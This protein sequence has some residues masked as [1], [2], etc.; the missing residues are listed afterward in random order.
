M[1]VCVSVSPSLGE[2]V[3][4]SELCFKKIKSEINSLEDNE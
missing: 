1:Y 3:I 4:W 2:F